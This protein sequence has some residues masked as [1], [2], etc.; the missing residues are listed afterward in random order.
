MTFEAFPCHTQAVERIIKEVD[1]ASLKVCGYETRN[2][3]IGSRLASRVKI[4]RFES[5]TNFKA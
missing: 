2:G 5:K 1:D 4:P 3:Y